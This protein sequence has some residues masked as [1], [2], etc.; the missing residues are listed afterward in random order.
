M[1]VFLTMSRAPDSRPCVLAMGNFDGVHLGHRALL[2]KAKERAQTLGLEW[3]VLTFWPHPT[4][5]L[6]KERAPKILTSRGQKRALLGQAGADF[7]VEQRF[8]IDFAQTSPERFIEILKRD[9]GVQAIVVGH[10]FS[11]GKRGSGN[12]KLLSERFEGACDIIEP[13]IG[14]GLRLSS[15]GVRLALSE[16]RLDDA[17]SML[18]R[19]FALDGLVIR[20]DGRG[21]TI[22]FPTLN[23]DIE[24]Y[25]QVPKFGVYAVAVDIAG[26]RFEGVANVG[27]RPTFEDASLRVEAH[28]FDVADDFYDLQAEVSFLSFL[29]P[30]ERFANLESLKRAIANDVAKARSYFESKS[31][32]K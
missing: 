32:P 15:T 13:V 23:L 21:R 27:I 16:G 22:G 14:L 31:V 11:F 9:L 4:L 24:E 5:V 17:K 20:G 25:R 10:D 19:N 3:G 1:N 26:R 29:R 7:V 8:S 6:A 30:E 2:K 28:L 18:G 12:A